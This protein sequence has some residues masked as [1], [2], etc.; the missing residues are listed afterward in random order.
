MTWCTYPLYI[1]K[2]IYIILLIHMAL[3]FFN[4]VI[5]MKE[6][7]VMYGLLGAV[8]SIG[9]IIGSS[10]VAA[11]GQQISSEYLIGIAFFPIIICML[12]ALFYER[13]H[14]IKIEISNM[15][16]VK[17]ISSLKTIRLYT[18]LIVVLVIISQFVINAINLKFNFALSE[19]FQSSGEKTQFLGKTYRLINIMTLCV[20]LLLVP[21]L[22]HNFKARSLQFLFPFIY[23]IVI[24]AGSFSL[25]TGTL[26]FWN[27]VM[28]ITVKGMDYSFFAGAKE[29]LYFSC[30]YQ[31]KFG[32]KYLVDMIFYR[33][34]KGLVSFLLIF[35]QTKSF[36]S[37]LLYLCLGLWFIICIALYKENKRLEERTV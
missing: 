29:L 5:D 35:Y 34:G 17:A 23:L 31:Q 3:A 24:F 11:Y 2:E 18:V 16:K 22:L 4:S 8:G 10:F 9:G 28:F 14:D 21:L 37:S 15:N 20:Q 33:A 13:G 32:L 25:G 30:S 12:V 6:A 7:K 19:V 26:L 1:L 36:I 27:S